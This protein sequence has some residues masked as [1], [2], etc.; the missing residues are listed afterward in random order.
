MIK[1]IMALL[2]LMTGLVLGKEKKELIILSTTSTENSG[3]FS[4][5][6]PEFEKDTGIKTKVIAVGTGKALQMGKDGEGDILI[7]HDKAKELEFVKEGHG[8]VRKDLMYNEFVVLGPKGNFKSL[9][10]TLNYISLNNLKFISRG[11][12]SGTHSK[13]LE[14]WKKYNI[15]IINKNWYISAGNGMG[16]TIQM[17]N[18]KLAYT[19]SDKATYLAMKDKIDLKIV[20]EKD[21]SLYNQYGVI[22]VN[23]NKNKMINKE[24][25]I[26]LMDWLLSKKGQ[27]LIGQYGVKEYKQS[28]FVPNGK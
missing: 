12:N 5:I 22:L 2:I 4:Y 14:L 8:T 9:K 16:S 25:A 17:A 21:V 10:E 26:K 24:G 3:F 27:N 11:D 23:P 6:L 13:E 28:L 19:L 1:K 7:V 15:D 20:F 18:E